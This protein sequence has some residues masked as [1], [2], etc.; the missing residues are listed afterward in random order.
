MP[1]KLLLRSKE[2][3]YHVT[4]RVNDREKFPL[5]LDRVW[6][7]LTNEALFITWV[8]SARFHAIVLMPNHI[9]MILSVPDFD[10]GKVMNIFVSNFTRECHRITGKSGR[11][12]G[13]PYFWSLISGTYY[14]S[15]ALKYVYRNP[16]K[17]GLCKRVGDYPF[18]TLYGLLGNGRLPVP[19]FWTLVGMEVNLPWN[20]ES[21]LELLP[22][23]D[24]A[25]SLEVDQLIKEG[26]KRKYF[27]SI[28]DRDTRKPVNTLE[29]LH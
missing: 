14:Y 20:G 26:L 17:S 13:G 6:D 21:T 27:A 25:F 3:P 24:Q 2:L 19:I 15:H 10:L 23:L 11:L 12:F 1:R 5:A 29:V 9:H 28:K 7:V 4:L 18:S 8:Y 16:V 22:W